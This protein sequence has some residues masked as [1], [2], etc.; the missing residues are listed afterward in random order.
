MELQVVQGNIVDQ[1]TDC[2]VVNLFEGVTRPG[3]AT[4]A[5]DMAL[6]GAIT[7][8]I[9]GGDFTGKAGD[10]A[11]LYTEG[12]LPSPRVLIV[13]LGPSDKFDLHGARKAA[14]VAQ[15][16]VSRLKGVHSYATI[17]HGA[18]IGALEPQ[19]AAQVLAEGALLAA[20]RVPNYKREA[21]N[22]GPDLCTVVEFNAGRLA[23]MTSAVRRGE[24][25]ARGVYT[26][27]DLS[28]EPGNVLYP[29]EFAQR[30]RALAERTGLQCTVL[31]EREMSDLSMNILLG[32]S[33]GSAREA[34][35]IILEHAP[36][37]VA[38]EPP[39]VLVGKGITFD[40]GG[41]SIKPAERMEEMKHDMS[42]AAAVVG[43]MQV[44][45]DLG[46]PRHVIGVAVCVENM[47]DGNAYR[48][49]DILVGMSGKSAEII[50]TDAEGRLV[51]ADALAYVARYH[52]KAV[53][54]LAT[55]TGA[56]GVALGPQ[57]AGLFSNDETL[58]S[59]IMAA[60]AQSGERVWPM[61]MWDEYLE[62]IKSEMAEVKN[63]A[64]RSSGVSS[65]AKFLEH[66][67]EGYPWAHLDIASM[68]WTNN[69]RDATTPRG[70]TGYGVRLLTDLA[71]IF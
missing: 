17:V 38:A 54:D 57:A 9:A 62:S 10:T 70:S 52:P 50:S 16:A 67:T 22:S 19:R 5:V 29:E 27:R 46:L 30:A 20:Y 6:D 21:A 36:V 64:G 58:Q 18:G 51:L 56:I 60:S 4:G 7:R 32:V 47:P 24:A 41:I 59:A 45:G 34:Q 23:A 14:A 53:V 13:G 31:G 49:G 35:F 8:L 3:G 42:G 15:K 63:S 65:S 37:G 1:Q 26:A 44:I 66:F 28:N 61:P 2:I 71:D 40:T 48:P 12:K 55:L 33:R 25:V 39:L 68:A 43:A 69:E 11:L